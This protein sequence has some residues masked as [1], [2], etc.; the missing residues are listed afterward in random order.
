MQHAGRLEAGQFVDFQPKGPAHPAQPIGHIYNAFEGRAFKAGAE[1][2]AKIGK[3]V[4]LAMGSGD[5]SKAG[6]T[7]HPA[8]SAC[9]I[10]GSLSEWS[11][12]VSHVRLSL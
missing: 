12:R 9:R 11:R 2:A 4:A 10:I 6:E 7:T 3:R 8:A 5:H 1:F